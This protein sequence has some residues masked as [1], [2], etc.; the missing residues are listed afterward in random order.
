VRETFSKGS[1]VNCR[2]DE[3]TAGATTWPCDAGGGRQ[4]PYIWGPPKL[5]WVAGANKVVA[6]LD[7]AIRRVYEVALPLEDERIRASGDAAGS[8]VNKLV[9]Y[10]RE[11]SPKRI[12]LIIVAEELGS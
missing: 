1:P 12:T 11:A 4:G 9:I 3:G 8:S 6:D 7:A 5:I 10:E 2:D